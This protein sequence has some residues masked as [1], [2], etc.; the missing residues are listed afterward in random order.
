MA[1]AR[2]GSCWRCGQ[3]LGNPANQT[4]LPAP[5]AVPTE[6]QLWLA[7]AIG[8][9]LANAPRID[10]E[11]LR[12]RARAVLLAYTNAFTEGNRT[13][14]ADI[15][16]C[17][18]GIFYSWFNGD[19]VPRIDTLFHTWYQLKLPITCLVDGACPGFSPEVLAERSREIRG[20]RQ[21]APKRS[22][23]QIRRA[24]EAAL[25][26]EPAP[27]LHELARRLGYSTTERLR[28]VDKNLCKQ[29]VRK[30]WKSG[31]SAWVSRRYQHRALRNW[32]N[33]SVLLLNVF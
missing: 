11:H 4:C 14:V 27:A 31:R 6:Y 19:Q 5:E 9:L 16:G 20:V 12:D 22:P 26:E 28:S 33:G 1:V 18:P 32:R 24:L 17:R 2:P 21:A 3:W 7:E 29:I 23:E 25:H 30:Y 13:A 8:E 10:P 15:A